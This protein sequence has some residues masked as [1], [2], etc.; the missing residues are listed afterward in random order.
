MMTGSSNFTNKI[1]GLIAHVDII[2]NQR[3][4]S[5]KSF[6]K[7]LFTQWLDKYK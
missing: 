5:F 6:F 4:E 7:Q 3:R 2:Y 1:T